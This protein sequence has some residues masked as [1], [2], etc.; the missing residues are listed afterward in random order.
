MFSGGSYL[1]HHIAAVHDGIRKFKCELC[2]KSY[3]HRE[4]IRRHMKSFHEGKRFECDSCDK[5]FTQEYHLKQH[6]IA[7]H[8]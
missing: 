5:S 2:D 8:K 4:G 6:V 1:R 7:A 3:A